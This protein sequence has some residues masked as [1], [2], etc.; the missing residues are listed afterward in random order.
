MIYFED[1]EIQI[2]DMAP[3]DARTITDE[4]VAQG[5]DQSVE[6]YETRLKDQAEGRAISLVAEYKGCVAGYINVYPDSKWA[7]LQ[8][9][10]TRR[11]SI[12]GFW[13]NIESMGS[14]AS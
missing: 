7:L 2:R 14:A 5:W 8:G 12:S 6:K 4:E 13:K 1:K 11:S 3:E 9:W 10:D